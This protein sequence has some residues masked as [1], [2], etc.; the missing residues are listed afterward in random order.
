MKGVIL[1]EINDTEN[2]ILNHSMC[3]SIMKL[4]I[5]MEMNDI[6]N[7]MFEPL[8]VYFYYEISNTHGNE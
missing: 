4:V 8:Y 5:L 6:E 7:V 1:I 2:A 3:T